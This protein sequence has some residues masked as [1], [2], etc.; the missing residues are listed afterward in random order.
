MTLW[1][2]VVWLCLFSWHT[3]LFL[4]PFLVLFLK[5]FMLPVITAFALVE[6]RKRKDWKKWL[7]YIL[8]PA[9][10]LGLFFVFPS[11]WAIWF[12]VITSIYLWILQVDI[13]NN[14]TLP[15]TA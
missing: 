14:S 7:F 4:W 3:L 5:A 8:C 12:F 15:S 2:L 6:L 1:N 10:L 13:P 11:N 9:F